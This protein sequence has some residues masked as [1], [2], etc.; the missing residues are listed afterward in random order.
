MANMASGGAVSEIRRV[1]SQARSR[2]C[3]CRDGLPRRRSATIVL[4]RMTESRI[5]Y[6][7][8]AGGFG[9][10]PRPPIGLRAAVQQN[11]DPRCKRILCS[12]NVAECSELGMEM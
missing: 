6:F 8:R 5:C 3:R 1:H 9:M 4:D 11:H 2:K 7:L 10:R 12:D